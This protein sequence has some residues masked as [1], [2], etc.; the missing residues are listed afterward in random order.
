[1]SCVIFGTFYVA[2]V[3][4]YILFCYLFVYLHNIFIPHIYRVN[5]L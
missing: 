2:K 1:M 4:E 3:P 5:Y